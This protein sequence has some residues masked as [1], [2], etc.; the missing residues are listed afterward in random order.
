MVSLEVSWLLGSSPATSDAVRLGDL[1]SAQNAGRSIV[2]NGQEGQAELLILAALP[3]SKPWGVQW[4]LEL[5]YS[6][7]RWLHTPTLKVISYNYITSL[8]LP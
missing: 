2:E 1:F 6:W 4:L 3:S 5:E 7:F 8:Y